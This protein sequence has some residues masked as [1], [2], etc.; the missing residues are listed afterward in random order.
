MTLQGILLSVFAVMLIA[1]YAVGGSIATPSEL[2]ELKTLDVPVTSPETLIGTTLTGTG[3][4]VEDVTL[5]FRNA[6]AASTTVTVSIKDSAGVVIGSGSET[7]ASALATVT[8][9]LTDTVTAAERPNLRNITV[10]AA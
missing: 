8:V 4:A 9:N 1:T 6:L 2:N 3:S 10:T 7:L 5:T